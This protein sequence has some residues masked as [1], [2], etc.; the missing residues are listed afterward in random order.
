[1]TGTPNAPSPEQLAL[2]AQTIRDVARARR[3]SRDDAEDFGQSVH[4]RFLE[5]G[6]D[7]LDR[8]E[9]RSS[10]RTYLTVVVNRMLLDWRNS[11]YGKWRPSRSAEAMGEHAVN[12]ERLMSRDGYSFDE[13]A[14]VL[15]MTKD[16]PSAAALRRFAERLPAR[17]K[18]RRVS[19]EALR[20]ME[21]P[22]FQDPIETRDRDRAAQH[23][24]AALAVALRQLTSEERWLIQARYVQDRTVRAAARA[25]H[26]DP[27]ALYRRYGRVLRTLRDALEATGAAVAAHRTTA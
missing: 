20:E 3:L 23:L 22:A 14:E 25:L 15:R 12:L 9:G 4:L 18:R 17:P 1:M 2:I 27:K 19:D 21:G 5:R 24:Y 16:A 7:I 11:M 8:F 13:A 10:L 6:Y 26:T